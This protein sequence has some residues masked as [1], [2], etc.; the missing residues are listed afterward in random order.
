MIINS[1]HTHFL[2]YV[3]LKTTLNKSI[4]IIIIISWQ[5]FHLSVSVNVFEYV[6]IPFI[7]IIVWALPN[8]Y[9]KCVLPLISHLFRTDRYIHLG[10][11]KYSMA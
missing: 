7:I 8:D 5:L 9:L 3:L 2:K 11:G 6:S 4:I 1:S 10:N